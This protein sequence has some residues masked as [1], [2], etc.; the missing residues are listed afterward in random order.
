MRTRALIFD[1]D[2][3]MIDSLG[4]HARSWSEFARHHGINRD[5][6]SWM[7]SANGRTG[8]ECVRELF[9]RVLSDDEASAL[10]AQKEQIYRD[11]FAPDFAEI[12]GFKEFAC[13]AIRRGLKIG[14][15]TAGDKNNISFAL[16]HLALATPPQ[17]RVGGDEGLAGK[18]QPDIFLAVAHQLQVSPAECIVFEDAPLGIEAA[19]RAGMRAV[20]ICSTHRREEL[21]SPHVVASVNNY[22][23]LMES[24]FLENLDV[25][26]T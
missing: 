17:A 13:R 9:D 22:I 8:L 11:L 12:K 3:T 14:V 18:P 24:S 7:R 15:G 4:H 1:M 25:A 5:M 19:R 2:G 21:D 6:P 10:V 26:S 23:E 20:A 16:Q